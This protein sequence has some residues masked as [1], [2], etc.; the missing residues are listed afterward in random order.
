[1]AKRPLVSIVV[2]NFNYADYV[3]GAIGTA[4]AQTYDRCEVVVV[5]DGSTDASRTV[6]AR[7]GDRI[8][9]V[10]QANS[11]QTAANN[12]GFAAAAGD[13]IMFLD[14]D[15]ALHP[16]A[17]EQI[18]AVWRDGVAK[19][20]FCLALMTADGQSKRFVFPYFPPELS[21]ARIRE[22]VLRTGL[23]LWPPT[24]GNAFSRSFLARVMPLSTELFPS[25]T[26]G[27]LNTAA[28]LYGD[29]LSVNKVLGYY[30]IHANNMQQAPV[31]DRIRR[32]VLYKRR[33]AEYLRARAAELQ[34][35]LP[36]D[37]LDQMIHLEGRIASLKLAPDLHPVRG[38][39]LLDLFRRAVR[40]AAVE[41]DRWVRRALH[42][43]WLFAV[44]LAPRRLCGRM[45]EFRFVPGARSDR[46]TRALE[47]LG[48]VR[49]RRADDRLSLFP[50]AMPPLAVSA[51]A[52]GRSQ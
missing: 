38:D 3:A 47:V 42:V 41:D 27:A 21:P 24:S 18:A 11:G 20:Q 7:F 15:D 16:E 29:V 10:L 37:L 2:I 17:A 39:T 19:V 23:Y 13:I 14:A 43:A 52:P 30:R 26:D 44:I 32:G 8:R 9:T 45:V 5:D 12:A 50:G 4:L 49:R 1:M 31:A 28:P 33:E 40:K 36:P 48:V 35:E 6:I 34:I 22:Q 46:I 51:E 25:M